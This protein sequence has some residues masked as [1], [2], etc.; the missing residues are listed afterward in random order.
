MAP[1]LKSFWTSYFNKPTKTL[2]KCLD[3][4][5]VES[6]RAHIRAAHGCVSIHSRRREKHTFGHFQ[7][8]TQVT[9]AHATLLLQ[10]RQ[11]LYTQ[12]TQQDA[13]QAFGRIGRH[14]S[15][16]PPVFRGPQ[17]GRPAQK[18]NTGALQAQYMQR[19]RYDQFC[20][21]IHEAGA[22]RLARPCSKFNER[23]EFVPRL[24]LR[25]PVH[26]L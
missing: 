26:Y 25:G 5:L 10:T 18:E 22:R 24:L 1:F 17:M 4:G 15:Q 7:A 12:A 16:I 19:A 9:A 21:R 8:N 6:G 20:G 14:R 2:K 23:R 13:Q 3:R 11:R